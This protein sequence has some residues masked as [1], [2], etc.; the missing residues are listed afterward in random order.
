M[1]C[2]PETT[3]EIVHFPQSHILFIL[4]HPLEELIVKDVLS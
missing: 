3:N 2:P 1:V 4:K